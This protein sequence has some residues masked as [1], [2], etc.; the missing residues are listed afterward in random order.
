MQV[1]K[2]D[3]VFHVDFPEQRFVVR[4]VKGTSAMIHG[5]SGEP[6]LAPFSKLYKLDSK[7]KK[8]DLSQ[9]RLDRV[10]GNCA[11]RFENVHG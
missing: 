11:G 6:F 10:D 7:F 9:L 4:F 5:S 1:R 2:H 8:A 3:R